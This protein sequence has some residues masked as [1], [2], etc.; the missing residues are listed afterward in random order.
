[1][2]NN[3]LKQF[4]WYTPADALVSTLGLFNYIV[5]DLYF[6]LKEKSATSVLVITT[7]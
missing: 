4:L 5:T 2:K 1:M 7:F 6:D 3:L